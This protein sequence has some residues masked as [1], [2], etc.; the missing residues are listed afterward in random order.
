M[1]EVIVGT[2]ASSCFVACVVLDQTSSGVVAQSRGI[3]MCFSRCA[4]AKGGARA[5]HDAQ[6]Q[7]M[8]LLFESPQLVLFFPTKP[9][10]IFIAAFAW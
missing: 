6:P 10:G 3:I 8:A 4:S 2:S 7:L 1:Y 5:S 9:H